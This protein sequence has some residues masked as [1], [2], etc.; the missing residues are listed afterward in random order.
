MWWTK[1]ARCITNAHR[2]KMI[3]YGDVQYSVRHL[4]AQECGKDLPLAAQK[5]ISG[6]HKQCFKHEEPLLVERNDGEISESLLIPKTGSRL[7]GKIEGEVK[8]LQP[9]EL[10][11]I[12]A[13]SLC[14][15]QK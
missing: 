15:S 2:W 10:S 9:S 12:I 4:S 11:E 8:R 6:L 3:S 13:I 1:L 7:L 14:R 5:E